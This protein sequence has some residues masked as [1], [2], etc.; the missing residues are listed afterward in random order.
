MRFQVF[1]CFKRLFVVC[2]PFRSYDFFLF[3][4]RLLLL[5]FS[6]FLLF[7]SLAQF[8]FKCRS[9]KKSYILFA[10]SWYNLSLTLSCALFFLFIFFPFPMHAAAINVQLGRIS[11]TTNSDNQQASKQASKQRREKF[12]MQNNNNSLYAVD[13]WC[14]CVNAFNYL[15]FL[16]ILRAS[17]K[18]RL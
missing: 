9:Q 18:I 5:F 11:L 8:L 12:R 7:S 14:R 4:N 13:G 17:N 1:F 2:L 16:L 10:S 6:S 3:L 15:V